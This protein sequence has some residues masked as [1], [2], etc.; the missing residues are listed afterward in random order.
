[1][2][3]HGEYHRVISLIQSIWNMTQSNPYQV[4][5]VDDASANQDFLEKFKSS[6]NP[7]G[8]Y[9]N[10]ILPVRSDKHLG[11]GGAVNLGLSKTKQPWV[12]ILQ[13]DCVIE[14]PNWLIEMGRSLVRLD[15][16]NVHMVSARSNNPGDGYDPR[17]KALRKEQSEDIILEDPDAALPLYCV[18]F[19]REL[20]NRIGGPLK[21]YSYGMYEDMELAYRMR[22]HGFKQ[23]ICGKS[24]VRHYAGST[25]TTISHYVSNLEEIIEENRHRCIQDIKSLKKTG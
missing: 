21:E 17:L 24:W 7:A 19:Q 4:C 20:L 9:E 12:C 15:K 5:L 10:Q 2:P 3:F 14:N 8:Y 22:H 13:S 6:Y 23:G 16:Q 11:F 1:V 18:M 25:F